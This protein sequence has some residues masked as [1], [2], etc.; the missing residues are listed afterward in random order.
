MVD[1]VLAVIMNAASVGRARE[2]NCCN[3][4]LS[5]YCEMIRSEKV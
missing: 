3:L 2:V 5:R 4:L 1:I